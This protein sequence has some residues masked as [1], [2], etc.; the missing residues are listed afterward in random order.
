[1]LV[2]KITQI[3][4]FFGYDQEI[5]HQTFQNLFKDKFSPFK[6]FN[7]PDADTSYQDIKKAGSLQT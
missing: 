6:I 2:K 7:R 5:A 3:S 1:M 4:N